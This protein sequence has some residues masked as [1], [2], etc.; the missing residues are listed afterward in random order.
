MDGGIQLDMNAVARVDR[1]GWDVSFNEY[2][3]A[4]NTAGF[5]NNATPSQA[6]GSANG[7]GTF[8]AYNAGYNI[9][10][11]HGI[12]AVWGLGSGSFF[13][14][15]TADGNYTLTGIAA[16][17]ND[18]SSV[19]G[20]GGF[21]GQSYAF[22]RISVIPGAPSAPALSLPTVSSLRYNAT[23]GDNGG[24][25]ITGR[26]VQY[27]TS[28]TFASGNTTVTPGSLTNVNLTGLTARTKYYVRSRE[29]NA[30]G[31]GAWSATVNADTLDYPGIPTLAFTS[32]TTTQIVT[33]LTDPA[34]TGG[35][36][37]ARETVISTSD[38]FA[39]ILD[40]KT[41]TTPTFT[42]LTRGTTYYSR[43]RVQ[44][45]TGW[46]AW[47]TTLV[48][49]T[50]FEVPSTPTGYAPHDIASTTAFS[51]M[52]TILDSGGG[53][54]TALNYQLN[55]TPSSVG[56]VDSTLDTAR[57]PMFAAL[58]EATLYYY[59][60][61]VSNGSL[62]SGWGAWESFTTLNT[63][64]TAP[65]SFATSALADFSATLGWAVPADLNG[66]TITGYR[67]VI[68]TNKAMTTGVQTADVSAATF[69]K[70]FVGLTPGTTYHSRVWALS[71]AGDGSR[72][73]LITFA[74]T[75]TGGSGGILWENVGGVWKQITDWENVGGV[76]KE[77]VL[78]ENVSGVWKSN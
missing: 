36:I 38:V 2:I 49:T 6:Y 31:N 20:D 59:R 61:R 67:I 16:S 44:N 57:E 70:V 42:G 78:W 45:S 53:P 58:A 34:Y 35:G 66:A 32:K 65:T 41:T 33:A 43:S 64:P 60:L 56:A 7:V 51:S 4:T 54:L 72:A 12:G 5:P 11:G 8:L 74:T 13:I 22:P 55:T 48:T 77:I 69:S 63:V 17:F 75:N 19:L 10:S 50:D 47:S 39:S 18:S 37:T 25:A 14:A 30:L 26:E 71:S 1:S 73:N 62:W 68:A 28:A 29:I 23:P 52:G 15:V 3:Y 9:P 40:T 27:S 76:W 46:S 24:S 21:S